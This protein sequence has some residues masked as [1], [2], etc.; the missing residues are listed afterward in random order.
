MLTHHATELN[1]IAFLLRAHPGPGLPQECR[2]GCSSL[3][4]SLLGEKNRSRCGH[5]NAGR[6]E[7]SKKSPQ[8]V[9]KK[10]SVCVYMC[11]EIKN[12][13]SSSTGPRFVSSTHVVFTTFYNSSVRDQT[14]SLGFI[15]TKHT[16]G[17]QTYVQAK[18]PYT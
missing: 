1:S 13:S 18:C 10:K 7:L 9:R 8:V 4:E 16:N 14:S 12:T 15:N 6:S 2:E 5:G 11:V 17:A 3:P